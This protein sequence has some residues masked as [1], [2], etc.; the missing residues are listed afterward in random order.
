MN[1]LICTIGSVSIKKQLLAQATTLSDNSLSWGGL[2][3]KGLWV[4]LVL[5]MFCSLLTLLILTVQWVFSWRPSDLAQGETEGICWGVV[6]T[7]C[8]NS[9]RSKLSVPE[10]EKLQVLSAHIHLHRASSGQVPLGQQ[11]PIVAWWSLGRGPS[12][13]LPLIS[14]HCRLFVGGGGRYVFM[15]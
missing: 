10:S 7:S 6:S 14:K 2:C 5:S 8:S 9:W 13:R 11:I 12:S 1:S 15:V 3:L 4:S